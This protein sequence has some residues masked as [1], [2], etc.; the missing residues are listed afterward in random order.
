MGLALACPHD[1]GNPEFC[2]LCDVRK[3]PVR[4]RIAWVK[5]LSDDDLEYL[6]TYHQ[7]CLQCRETLF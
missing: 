2:P 5:M 1:D 4:Q 6:G 7:I 3:L